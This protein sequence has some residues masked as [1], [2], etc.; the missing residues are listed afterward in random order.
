M[1]TMSGSCSE[2][3]FLG[4]RTKTIGPPARR[5]VGLTRDRIAACRRRPAYNP[6]ELEPRR[7]DSNS[8]GRHLEAESPQLL[9]PSICFHLEHLSRVPSVPTRNGLEYS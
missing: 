7:V 9:R 2:R 1:S 8:R 5:E 4:S 3:P 6:L